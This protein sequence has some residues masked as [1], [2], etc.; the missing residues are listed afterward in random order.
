[1]IARVGEVLRVNRLARRVTQ[2]DLSRR[3][4]IHRLTL[5]QI[6]RGKSCNVESVE[7]LAG[8]LGLDPAA[9]FAD[10]YALAAK[11]GVHATIRR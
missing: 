3:A 8:A 4:G 1:M 6:E 10:G 2:S 9:V 11:E 5:I 7:A